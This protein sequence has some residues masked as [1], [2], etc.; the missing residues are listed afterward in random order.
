[1]QG[2]S[3]P[4]SLQSSPQ[5]PEI[6]RHVSLRRC[7]TGDLKWKTNCMRSNVF[8]SFNSQRISHTCRTQI[9]PVAQW[10]LAGWITNRHMRG[11]FGLQLVS[12]LRHRLNN[13]QK[14]MPG[15]GGE[16]ARV[17]NAKHGGTAS[18][19][20][21]SFWCLSTARCFLFTEKQC[22]YMYVCTVYVVCYTMIYNS[23]G[24]QTSSWPELVAAPEINFDPAQDQPG[25]LRPVRRRQG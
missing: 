16:S 24:G 15:S 25:P 11:T 18:A 9:D 3:R 8:N 21:A 17:S 19:C 13:H 7:R 12:F 1:M 5:L 14:T 10:T 4:A 6:F 2:H 22:I 23:Q 20:T